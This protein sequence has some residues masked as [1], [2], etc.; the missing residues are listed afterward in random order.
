MFSLALMR[1]LMTREWGNIGSFPSILE[2]IRRLS[3]KLELSGFLVLLSGIASFCIIGLGE[4]AI[5][6]RSRVVAL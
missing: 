3:W 1:G 5:L 6:W 4:V 2:I